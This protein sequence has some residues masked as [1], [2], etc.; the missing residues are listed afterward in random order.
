MNHNNPIICFISDEVEKLT[1][2][3]GKELEDAVVEVLRS[4]GNDGGVDVRGE[5]FGMPFV[6]QCKNWESQQIGPSIVRELIGALDLY[7][8]STIGIVVIPSKIRYNYRK[9]NWEC[10]YTP[11]AYDIAMKSSCEIILT[12]I[13]DIFLDLIRTILHQISKQIDFLTD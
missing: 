13:S 2:K 12:D 8:R 3:K 9:N 10:G 4:K 1:S 5:L 6:V 11:G 7:P